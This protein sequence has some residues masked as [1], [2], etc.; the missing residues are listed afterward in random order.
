MLSNN[1][2]LIEFLALKNKG[3]RGILECLPDS[4]DG[5]LDEESICEILYGISLENF[6]K[7]IEDL[8]PL[9]MV[10]S[11]RLGVEY[12]GFADTEQNIFL[13]KQKIEARK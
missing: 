11:S 3:V 5:D 1:F 13:V 9:C 4:E 2:E 6:N 8:L 12:Q 10:A 7:L